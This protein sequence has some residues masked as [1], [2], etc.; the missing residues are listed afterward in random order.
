MLGQLS[1]R[2]RSTLRSVQ[3]NATSDSPIR[4]TRKAG[5]GHT[6]IP[7]D[8]ALPSC[9]LNAN[10][11]RKHSKGH[12]LDTHVH[13]SSDA[14]I[15]IAKLDKQDP[16]DII[17]LIVGFRN[18]N[19]QFWW[20]RT[21][22]QLAELL[23]YAGYT[24]SEQY[25]EL[26]F[27][28][29]HVVPELGAAPDES[30]YLQWRTPHTPDGT[31]LELSWEWGLEGK[32]TIRTGFE[33]IGSLAGTDIDPY[34][35][36]ETDTWIKHLEDQGLVT[37]LDLEWYR[38][39][40]ETVL[41]SKDTPPSNEDRAKL[42]ENDLFEVAPV[43]GTFVMR[44]IARSGPMIKAYMYPGLKGKELGISKSDVVFGAIKALPAEQYRS[45][46]FEPLQEYL[47][48]AARK[49]NM[50]IHI[51]SFDLISPSRSRV[52]IYTRAPNTS[53][54]YLMDALT[55]GGRND[56]TMYSDQVIR[57]VQD[58]WNIFTEG[59][60]DELPQDGSARGPGFYFTTQAG[61]IPT[62][63]VYI[64]PG[65]FCKNDMEVLARLR[66]YF[67][68]RRDAETMLPQMRNYEKAL[69]AI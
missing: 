10:N 31:P 13:R 47:E 53:M 49:W 66:R 38:H 35:R 33:P 50:E 5:S 14:V 44:D 40:T 61:K 11:D 20:D 17:N 56:L 7:T 15:H 3:Q 69:E 68:T 45:L 6:P 42:A 22:K 52:K 26:L 24:K 19:H 23:R 32:G 18:R 9:D 65:P 60:P 30:G 39:F 41:P 64:S 43:G 54:E 27:F 16:F 29:M 37:G 59:A 55:I 48:E 57:D 2:L 28:A 62:P 36:H 21:G 12:T 63:K 25:T 4:S 58:F 1:N 34:N 46:T 67:S 8:D 51:F